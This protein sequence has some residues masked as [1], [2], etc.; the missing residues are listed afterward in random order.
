MTTNVT[1]DEIS[2]AYGLLDQ[3]NKKEGLKSFQE[4]L[5]LAPDNMS[6]VNGA[7][8]AYQINGKYKEAIKLYD[9]FLQKTGGTAVAL[10]N[11]SLCYL[12]LNK[13]STVEPFEERAVQ[14]DSKNAEFLASLGFIKYRLNKLDE[15]RAAFEQFTSIVPDEP[16]A[17]VMLGQIAWRLAAKSDFKSN[18]EKAVYYAEKAYRLKPNKW[19]ARRIVMLSYLFR[20]NLARAIMTGIGLWPVRPKTP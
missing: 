8:I 4:L 16:D 7:A 9:L 2:K 13:D 12:K 17:I 1:A 15:A 14:L 20:G 11:M 19:L 6:V 10:H 5:I 18:A 3:K